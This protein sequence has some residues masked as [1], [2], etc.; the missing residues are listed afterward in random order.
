MLKAVPLPHQHLNGSHCPHMAHTKSCQVYMLTTYAFKRTQD[1]MALQ[2]CRQPTRGRLLNWY[3]AYTHLCF[4]HVCSICMP[5]TCC[6]LDPVPEKVHKSTVGPNSSGRRLKSLDNMHGVIKCTL[7]RNQ[8]RQSGNLS[9]F[10]FPFKWFTDHLIF[11][12]NRAGLFFLTTRASDS[13]L[14]HKSHSSTFQAWVTNATPKTENYL[15]DFCDLGGD[16]DHA[17]WLLCTGS[18]LGTCPLGTLWRR[19]APWWHNF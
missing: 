2:A 18:G 8:R 12:W 14:V 7:L 19:K 3:R 6:P 15:I 9:F 11:S 16:L 1:C 13:H 10:F 5:G 17:K 4:D